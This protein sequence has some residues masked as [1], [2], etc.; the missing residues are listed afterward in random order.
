MCVHVSMWSDESFKYVVCA[1]IYIYTNSQIESLKYSKN[2]IE[3][4]RKRDGEG[5]C[6]E[7]LVLSSYHDAECLMN[8]SG[9]RGYDES[10]SL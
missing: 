9:K 7:T 10:R 4:E 1:Y 3:R 8:G 2:A 5:K 6:P